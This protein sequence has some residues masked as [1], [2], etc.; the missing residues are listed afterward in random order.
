MLDHLVSKR[1]NATTL[2]NEAFIAFS[3]NKTSE[4]LASKDD[5]ELQKLIKE[6]S[7]VGKQVK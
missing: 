6:E 2:A 3:I 1:P 4:W 5:A 7:K